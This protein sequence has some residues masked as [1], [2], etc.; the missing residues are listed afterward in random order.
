M[1][2]LLL[3]LVPALR[4]KWVS[5]RELANSR[6]IWLLA[7]LALGAVV[8]WP[9]APWLSLMA[10]WFLLN[11]RSQDL[12]PSLVTW[13]AI[14]A[15]WAL[16]RGLPEWAWTYLPYTWTAIL[17]A[18]V[19]LLLHQR[20]YKGVGRPWGVLGSPPCCAMILALLGPFALA[21]HGILAVPLGVG[22]W[23][24]SSWLAILATLVGVVVLVPALVWPATM[25]LAVT[26]A[27]LAYELSRYPLGIRRDTSG[28]VVRRPIDIM[29]RGRSMDGIRVRLR[30]WI[31]LA[32]VWREAGWRKVLRG[33]GP[34]TYQ[35]SA[36][37]WSFRYDLALP[38]GDAFNDALQHIHE[39]GAL[40]GLAILAFCWP[41]V[42]HLRLSDLYSAAWVVGVVLSLGH[43][44]M[45][46]P[47]TALVFLTASA[48]LA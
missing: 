21:T 9:S 44:P 8:L 37:R 29:P 40:G 42:D 26:V 46:W 10:L 12:V 6:D 36:K 14:G 39:Y 43:W 18:H 32:H 24:T 28:Q 16:L 30:V 11:W 35:R 7:V 23:L 27:L 2:A 5:D 15:S 47:S 22:L 3:A 13:A 41:I 1:T 20:I 4:L 19:A 45:R 31:V 34:G 38:E 17:L 48:R 33:H 25:T